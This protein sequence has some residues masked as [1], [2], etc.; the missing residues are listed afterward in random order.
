MHSNWAKAGF[1]EKLKGLAQRRSLDDFSSGPILT[2]TNER[3]L[4]HVQSLL[5][6]PGTQL[7]WGG[8]LLSNHKI[9]ACYGS[10]KPT[11]IKVPL[12][13]ML[14]P[15]YFKLVSTE[16]FGPF[17]VSSYS[18]HHIIRDS[19]LNQGCHA[20]MAFVAVAVLFCFVYL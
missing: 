5:K 15:E 18:I 6:I 14:K 10:F 11:A 7:L 12:E 13:Q 9:P 2:V 4:N 3:F 17:Q 1:L 20:L 8:D 16:I 19:K